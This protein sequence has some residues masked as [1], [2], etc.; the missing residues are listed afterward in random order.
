MYYT[1]TIIDG[2]K[3]FEDHATRALAEEFAQDVAHEGHDCIILVPFAQIAAKEQATDMAKYNGVIPGR[4]FPG[5][6]SHNRRP[7]HFA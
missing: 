7:V 5:T 3:L 2:E 1:L 6:A 4:D